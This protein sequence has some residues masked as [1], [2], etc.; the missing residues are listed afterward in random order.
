[1]L[2]ALVEICPS[3]AMKSGINPAHGGT[4]LQPNSLY[5]QIQLYC[6]SFL[7]DS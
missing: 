5:Q 1:M 4:V 7:H 6:Y 2:Q 3:S